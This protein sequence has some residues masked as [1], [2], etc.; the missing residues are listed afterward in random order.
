MTV[1]V[2]AQ[3]AVK[4]IAA[5]SSHTVALV[6]VHLNARRSSGNDLILT[7]PAD[8]IGFTLQSTVALTPPVTW[9]DVANPSAVLN[10]QWTVTNSFSS[11]AQ[12]YRLRK[13]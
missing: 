9:I 7:W 4:A 12:F 10:A 6:S 1:P 13:P 3:S 11:S 5:G 8:A 2:T